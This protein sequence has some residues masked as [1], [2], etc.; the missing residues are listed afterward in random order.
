VNR[1]RF[2]GR[3]VDG[4]VGEQFAV[5][6]AIPALRSI[7]RREAS[8]ELVIVSGCD[9]LNLVG[10]VLDGERVPAV[11]GARILF[12]DGVAVAAWVSGEMQWLVDGNAEKQQRWREAL[13]V[14]GS[15]RRVATGDASRSRS[16]DAT[17]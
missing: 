17:R 14:R 12:E 9:P 11:I 10:T 8:G 6:E 15:A 5:P 13:G 16:A 2:G 7:A 4:L 3:F 1:T